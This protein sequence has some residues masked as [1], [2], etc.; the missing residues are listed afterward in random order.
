MALVI[1]SFLFKNIILL[2]SV[3]LA[4]AILSMLYGFL[5]TTYPT[6]FLNVTLATI[7]IV[8]I[9][10]YLVKKYKK[11]KGIQVDGN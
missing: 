3:N 11:G 8:F 10:I 4:G 7:N 9:V 5:T 1:L 6:A 2:R